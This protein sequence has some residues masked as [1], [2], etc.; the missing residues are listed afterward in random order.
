ME[1]FETIAPGNVELLATSLEQFE[2]LSTTIGVAE[3]QREL[4]ESLLKTARQEMS[5]NMITSQWASCSRLK[6]HLMMI[7]RNW[8]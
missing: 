7:H 2:T 3:G 8:K 4:V 5:D 1:P 6:S